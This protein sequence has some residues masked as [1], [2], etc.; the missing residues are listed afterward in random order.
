MY[1][2]WPSADLSFG[3][4]STAYLLRAARLLVVYDRRLRQKYKR[5][6]NPSAQKKCM[7][8]ALTACSVISLIVQLRF[9][10]AR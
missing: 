10:T 9:A 6:V 7:C 1:H 5:F 4:I 8:A 3:V 2:P